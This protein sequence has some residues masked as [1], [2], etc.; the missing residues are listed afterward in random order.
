MPSR[1]TETLTNERGA[2]RNARPPPAQHFSVRDALRTRAFFVFL[3]SQRCH[4]Q[5]KSSQE[6][7]AHKADK[8]ICD[9]VLSVHINR[10]FWRPVY[11]CSSCRSRPI[12][13]CGRAFRSQVGTLVVTPAF[14]LSYMSARETS[15]RHF[16]WRVVK[17]R[18]LV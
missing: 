8:H 11:F 12:V 14:E 18:M 7:E 3:Y 6:A 16:A 9:H 15:R 10:R 2:V 17:G 5:N 13:K 1:S 4:H